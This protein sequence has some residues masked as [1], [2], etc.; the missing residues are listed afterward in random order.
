MEPVTFSSEALEF[1]AATYDKNYSATPTL[2]T[3]S[4]PISWFFAGDAK[5]PEKASDFPT[6]KFEDAAKLKTFGLTIDKDKGTIKA[7]KITK[8]SPDITFYVIA[9]N[10][11][12]VASQ[13]VTLSITHA[14]PKFSSATKLP[15]G[16]K[17]VAYQ[18]S[19][20]KN[21][22]ITAEGFCPTF[23]ISVND[24]DFVSENFIDGTKDAILQGLT[25]TVAEDDSDY[26]DIN[27]GDNPT[28]GYFT[29]N[30]LTISGTPEDIT[31][32]D[33]A[34]KAMSLTVRA[35]GPNYDPED[36]TTYTDKA[37]SLLV[38]DQA[39]KFKAS[40]FDLGTLVS[41]DDNMDVTMNLS[42]GTGDY[43]WTVTGA[44]SGIEVSFDTTSVQDSTDDGYSVT[45]NA[46]E[47]TTLH[48]ATT[49]TKKTSGALKI[50]VANIRD[51]KLKANATLNFK[52]GA[53]A[54]HKTPDFGTAPSDSS[55][56]PELD[57]SEKP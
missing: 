23:L 55:A 26:E 21:P 8:Y 2:S 33:D 31:S 22:T 48:I 32:E 1:K 6:G 3:G 40:T 25:F 16:T 41:M 14:K 53:T 37:F 20:K 28:D 27:K 47:T 9:S 12:S 15:E 17:N 7:T 42:A 44:A 30:T 45:V 35:I 29:K 57:I 5:A 52:I 10:E 38:R 18:D 54:S 13:E 36:S 43:K 46:T 50:T 4:K 34:V 51:S 24:G 56:K 11:V 49:G 39:P 19:S